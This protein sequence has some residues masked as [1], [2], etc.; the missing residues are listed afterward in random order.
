MTEPVPTSKPG[1]APSSGGPEGPF[2]L[3]VASGKG[4]VG[5][6]HLSV[7]LS[8]SLTKDGHRVL[9]V[10]GDLGLANV[11]VM[12]G[13]SPEHNAGH[14]LSGEHSF[15]EVVVK[16]NERLHVLPAGTALARMAELDMN[17]QVELLH[18]L[19]LPTRPYDFVI[20][21]AGA[22]IGA[23]VRL[24]LA[25][26]QEILVVMNPETTSLTDAYALVKVAHQAG[27]KG[28]F[29]VVVNRVRLADQGREMFDCLN[30][31][32]RSFLGLEVT[33]AGYVYRDAI[34]ERALR[35]QQPFVE[36]FPDSPA[37]KCV[38]QLAKRLAEGAAKWRAR[39][40]AGATKEAEGAL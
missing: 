2:V 24:T 35:A 16:A 25:M 19:A 32:T 29:H 5:K 38:G 40:R 30:S 18:R 12:L 27:S 1:A 15:E 8:V 22:G 31:A 3:T 4:G 13:L 10:D 28:P 26:A 9:L 39:E 14:L 20:I 34:V 6:T 33:Y 7:N 11:D 37:A 23:N 21:D 36:S 17:D